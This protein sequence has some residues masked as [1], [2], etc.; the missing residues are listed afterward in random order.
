VA[1]TLQ[2]SVRGHRHGA[3]APPKSKVVVVRDSVIATLVTA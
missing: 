3:E 1:S 2:S